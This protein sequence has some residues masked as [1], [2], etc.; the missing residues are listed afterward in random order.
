MVRRTTRGAS[1]VALA[2]AAASASAA[3]LN[4]QINDMFAGLGGVSNYTAPGA[5]RGQAMNTYSA[6]SLMVH[7][8]QKRITLLNYELPHAE[9][10][11]AGFTG[12]GGSF[13][14]ISGQ[15][16]KDALKSIT[17]SLP[18]VAFK[19]ALEVV[20]PLLANNMGWAHG[21]DFLKSL[22]GKNSCEIA[23]AM[24]GTAVA[25]TGFSTTSA[26]RSLAM[27]FGAS[28][29]ADAERMCRTNQASILDQA[30]TS[31]DPTVRNS[32]PF[33]GNLIWES[34]R[35][36]PNL[37]NAERELIMSIVGTRIYYPERPGDLHLIMPT[38]T[39]VKTLLY[40]EADAALSSG[41]DIKVLMLRCK[42]GDF[43]T[44][45]E[46]EGQQVTVKSFVAR[47]RDM[48]T[49]ISDKLETRTGFST[50]SPEVRF[51]NM[52]AEPVYKML[53]VATQS[54]GPDN[55][56]SLID[57]YSEVIAAD[58]AYHFLSNSIFTGMQLLGKN[59]RLDPEQTDQVRE[60]A[61][62]L[63]AQLQLLATERTSQYQK[64][65]SIDLLT[66]N[67]MRLERTMH[68]ASPM[69]V[70]DLLGRAARFH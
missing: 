10:S 55:A 27:T 23:S 63:R 36:A 50:D 17:A 25:K 7:V 8:P 31:A 4:Q 41:G 61:T 54:A 51:V 45:M 43:D 34:L 24:V 35:R 56:N 21:L 1:A 42:N 46:V 38:I 32:A 53:S 70:V 44:C 29:P 12:S 5:F 30:N 59:A 52:T 49:S 3:D 48:L 11:C 62:A 66:Q 68:N 9:A 64:I 13:S 37:D 65:G 18:A 58:Y 60:M 16:L 69:Q 2:L 28:D 6:G 57:M 39:N 19:V 20:S 67:I 15:E 47:V 26:C 40:G 14:M 22:N 33:T